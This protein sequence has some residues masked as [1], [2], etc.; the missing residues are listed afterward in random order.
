MTEPTITQADKDIAADIADLWSDGFE[1]QAFAVAAAHREAAVAELRAENERLR[2]IV[3]SICI[4]DMVGKMGWK[5]YKQ[6]QEG[7]LTALSQKETSHD[8]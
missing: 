6:A 2:Q 4:S 1:Q 8:G 5:S 7:L 3:G